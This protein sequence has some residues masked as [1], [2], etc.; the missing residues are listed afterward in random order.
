MHDRSEWHFQLGL[1]CTV[2]DETSGNLHRLRS[3]L[4]VFWLDW[5]TQRES[6]P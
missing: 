5:V 6:G 3:V 2:V 1:Y 4:H